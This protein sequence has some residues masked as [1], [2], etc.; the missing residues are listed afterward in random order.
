MV[1]TTSTSPITVIIVVEVVDREGRVCPDAAV[2]CE[3][4]VTGQGRLLA[5]A[6][7]DLRDYEPA[8]TARVTTWHGR[9]LL[10]VRSTEKK[11]RARVSIKS[12]LPTATLT[13][14]CSGK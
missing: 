2:S 12:N 7:A 8:T 14:Q 5:F 6:S 13:I 4:A 3:A 10:V 1:L 9:A 11:G